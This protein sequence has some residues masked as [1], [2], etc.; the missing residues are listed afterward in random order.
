MRHARGLSLVE[1][2]VVVVLLISVIAI[3]L[4]VSFGMER[5]RHYAAFESATVAL[6]D[7]IQRQYSHEPSTATI[8]GARLWTNNLI[9]SALRGPS[10]ASPLI[11]PDA[12]A[13]SLSAAALTG[14]T[15]PSLLIFSVALRRAERAE[16]QRAECRRLANGLLP[17]FSYFA[18]DGTVIAIPRTGAVDAVTADAIE[19]AVVAECSAPA[20]PPVMHFGFLP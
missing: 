5:D 20:T 8:T 2:L 9:P 7:A 11:G 18:F 15:T 17:H 1:L 12:A 13:M 3:A 14:E 4:G 19:N 16:S 6:R 10:A